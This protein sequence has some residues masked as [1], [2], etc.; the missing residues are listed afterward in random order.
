MTV[1]VNNP[2]FTVPFALLGRTLAVTGNTTGNLLNQWANPLR[3]VLLQVDGSSDTRIKTIQNDTHRAGDVFAFRTTVTSAC[4]DCSPFV[5]GSDELGLEI[6]VRLLVSVTSLSPTETAAGCH[7]YDR[8]PGRIQERS[9]MA[10]TGS[11]LPELRFAGSG[12]LAS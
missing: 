3:T 1:P 6:V 10:P 7:R 12:L 4:H 2:V 8:K 9:K 11:T 5:A